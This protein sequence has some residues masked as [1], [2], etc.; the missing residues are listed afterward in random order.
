M[1]ETEP[2]SVQELPPRREAEQAP[3]ATSTV[4]VVA[5]YR[6]PNRSQVHPYLM[7]P[8][9]MQ[10]SSEQIHRIE[11]R[12]PYER[13][14]RFSPRKDDCHALAVARIAC[15]RAVHRD[16][17]GNE[18][19]PAQHCVTPRNA[20]R[21]QLGRKQ[22]VRPLGASHQQQARCVLVET[23]HQPSTLGKDTA[24][25]S[26]QQSIDQ[27]TAPVARSW[28]ND[29]TSRLVYDDDVLVLVHNS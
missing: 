7:G 12:Q 21:R 2:G 6:V 16:L 28:M 5:N 13:G 19:T 20:P 9:S 22:P 15:E 1:A 10:V 8:P 26:A 14:A 25:R 3:A 29:H 17:V 4:Y 11:P 18:V 27:R 24:T 23:V